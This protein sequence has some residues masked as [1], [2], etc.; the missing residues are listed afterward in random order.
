V[1]KFHTSEYSAGCICI[2]EAVK[3]GL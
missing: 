3:A 1:V 2:R